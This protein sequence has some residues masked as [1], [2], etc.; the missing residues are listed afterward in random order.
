MKID[1]CRQG[2]ASDG[3]IDHFCR[4]MNSMVLDC[5]EKGDLPY[6]FSHPA[7]ALDTDVITGLHLTGI[8]SHRILVTGE[9]ILPTPV[10]QEDAASRGPEVPRFPWWTLV[11]AGA[12]VVLAVYVWWSG[13]PA[14]RRARHARVCDTPGG[15][16]D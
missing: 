3:V 8:N 16:V 5:I 11:L 13:L 15:H 6:V 10:E 14:T 4:E 12:L 9:R 2:P 7:I 1:N